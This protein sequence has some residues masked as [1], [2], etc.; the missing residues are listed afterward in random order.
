[1]SS[2]VLQMAYDGRSTAATPASIRLARHDLV[3]A[4]AGVPLTADE[5]RYLDW[6]LD[7]DQPTLTAWAGIIRKARALK[8]AAPKTR[9]R[10]ASR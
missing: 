6:V 3:A 2:D 7:W 1:M 8:P 10:I 5:Q 9:S 4:L